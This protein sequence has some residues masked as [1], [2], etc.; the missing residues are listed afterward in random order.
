MTFLYYAVYYILL[1]LF[2][3][4]QYLKRPYALRLIWFRERL[5]FYPKGNTAINN[6]KKIWIHAV[7]VGEVISCVPLINKLRSEVTRSLTLSVVTDTGRDVAYKKFPIGI[8]IR[9]IPFDLPFAINRAI[10]IERPDIFIIIETE[11]WPGIITCMNKAGVP[12]LIL[13]GRISEKSFK[14]Y[15]RLRFYLKGILSKITFFGVQSDIYRDRIIELG[16]PANKVETIGNFK[17]DTAPHSNIPEWTKI[18]KGQI[19]VAGST[20][21]LEEA[22][23]LKAF[24]ELKKEF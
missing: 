24:I 19:I 4:P 15:K 11:I 12:I 21:K 10:K 18:L 20:H 5:G 3:I 14:G 6:G 16:A 13:N 7:S 22:I 17:F 9:Y 1:L 8:N 23:V 2:F